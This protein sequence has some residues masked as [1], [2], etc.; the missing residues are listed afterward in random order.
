LGAVFWEVFFLVPMGRGKELG[1]MSAGQF[2]SLFS[3]LA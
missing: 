2:E 3:K 1:Q